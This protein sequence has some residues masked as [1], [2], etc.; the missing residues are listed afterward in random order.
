MDQVEAMLKR[1]DVDMKQT[2]MDRYQSFALDYTD[3]FGTFMKV[4]AEPSNYPVVYHC[5][6]GKDRTGF[7]TA[8]LFKTLGFSTEDIVADYLTTNLYD[9]AS[10]KKMLANTSEA[11]VPSIG[12]HEEQIRASLE[13]IDRQYGSFDNYLKQ[14]L[15]LSDDEIQAIRENIQL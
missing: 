4:L 1:Y 12:A 7:A 10:Q 13:A 15:K 2:R 9:Y 8:V 3:A 5:Q 14:G 11:L 6:G